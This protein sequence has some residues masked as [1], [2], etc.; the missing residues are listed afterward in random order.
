[1][2]WAWITREFSL[3]IPGIPNDFP[4]KSRDAIRFDIGAENGR[5]AKEGF[6][7]EEFGSCRGSLRQGESS[8]PNCIYRQAGLVL[9]E[10]AR[11]V[12]IP[13]FPPSIVAPLQRSRLPGNGGLSAPF[14]RTGP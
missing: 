1:M 11:R 14:G 10:P 5:F 8:N 3:F 9:H 2:I 12:W 13:G 4:T 7:E 6:W